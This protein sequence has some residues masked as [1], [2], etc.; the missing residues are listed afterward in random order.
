[1]KLLLQSACHSPCYS[2]GAPRLVSFLSSS[3]LSAWSKEY[4]IQSLELCLFPFVIFML[5][6]W[7]QEIVQVGGQWDQAL[8]DSPA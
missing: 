4:F 3:P 1:M 7:V 8:Q 6:K 2:I 5:G